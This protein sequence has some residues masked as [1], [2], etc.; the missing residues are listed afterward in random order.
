[1]RE[2]TTAGAARPERI[3]GMPGEFDRAAFVERFGP[4]FEHSPWVAERAWQKRPFADLAAVHRAMVEVVREAGQALQLTLLRA[5]P[6]LWGPE[7]RAR[8]MTA[9][10]A[11]EQARAGLLAMS[12]AEAARIDA[13]NAAHRQKFGFPFIIAAMTHTRAQIFAEF[14]RRLALETDAEQAACLEQVYV[15]TGLRMQRLQAQAAA[16]AA[17]ER[18]SGD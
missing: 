5:H 2:S 14:E 7:A 16:S 17:G 8:Q 18:D 11:A 10:S 12:D 13:L 4:V 15:I 3:A 6:E 9:D 1:M